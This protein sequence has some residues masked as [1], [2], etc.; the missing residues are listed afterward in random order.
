MSASDASGDKG[1]RTDPPYSRRKQKTR[2]KTV[3]AAASGQSSG[4]FTLLFQQMMSAQQA[5]FEFGK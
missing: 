4:D 1:V 3:A 5:A 2:P